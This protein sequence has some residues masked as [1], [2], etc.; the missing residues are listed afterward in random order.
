MDCDGFMRRSRSVGGHT[1][2]LLTLVVVAVVVVVVLVS[3]EKKEE[4]VGLVV[5]VHK[6]TW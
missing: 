5:W 3:D 6:C 2:H 1:N 4:N